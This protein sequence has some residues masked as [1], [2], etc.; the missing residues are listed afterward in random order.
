MKTTELRI[1]NLVSYR[2]I[3]GVIKI[4]TVHTI[5]EDCIG[6]NRCGHVI[7]KKDI[8]GIKT[9][10]YW[11]H[12]LGFDTDFIN[13][14]NDEMDSRKNGI[15]IDIK[16]FSYSHKIN[17]NHSEKTDVS[18]IHKLQNLY[19]TLTGKELEIII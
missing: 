16:D 11:L 1:G 4:S 15:V 3:D 8:V 14:D 10:L 5:Y 7:Y 19:F 13:G 12:K 9:D 2:S 6:V 17:E 18:K